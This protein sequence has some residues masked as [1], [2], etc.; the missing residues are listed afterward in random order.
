MSDFNEVV[1]RVATDR[2]F[3]EDLLQDL[4]GTLSAHNYTCSGAEL[5][6]LGQLDRAKLDQLD[7][8]LLDQVVGGALTTSLTLTSSFSTGLPLL[9]TSLTS[10]Q[11]L[12]SGIV[13]PGTMASGTW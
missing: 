6:E 3:R 7:E 1:K 13:R 8:C 12:L 11:G 9:S 4:K 10:Q 2:A 5:A